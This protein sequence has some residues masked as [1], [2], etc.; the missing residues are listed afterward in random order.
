[1]GRKSFWR[2]SAPLRTLSVGCGIVPPT[3]IMEDAMAELLV[4]EFDGVDETDYANVSAQ[5]GVDPQTGAGE[6]PPGL[7]THLAGMKDGGSAYVIEVW[8]SQEAQAE[9]MQSRL[10]PAMAAGGVTAT[11]TVTWARLLAH[12]NPGL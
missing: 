7:I 5:L 3:G 12:Q 8:E 2:W 11:P 9:F 1:M 4:L 10:G 6:W